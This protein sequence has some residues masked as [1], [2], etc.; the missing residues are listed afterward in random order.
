VAW[1][2][3]K[4]GKG[5]LPATGKSWDKDVSDV[6]GEGT[7]RPGTKPFFPRGGKDRGGG[8]KKEI[9]GKIPS[10]WEGEH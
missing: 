4:Y 1:E 8:W 7:D 9:S 10:K 2:A 3:P 6:G 5:P